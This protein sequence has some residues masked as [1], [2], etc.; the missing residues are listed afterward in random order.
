MDVPITWGDGTEGDMDVILT[1]ANAGIAS[2]PKRH[3][4]GFLGVPMGSPL[5]CTVS[6]HFTPVW[7]HHKMASN[8]VPLHYEEHGH[9]EPLILLHGFGGSGIDWAPF[10]EEWAADF[11]IIVPDLRGHGQSANPA[12]EFRHDAAAGDVQALLDRLGVESC[13]GL[14][15]SCGGNV[16]L[17]LATRQPERM[18]AMVLVSATSHF[19]EQARTIMRNYSFDLLPEEEKEKTR[20]RHPGG[21]AQIDTLFCAGARLRGELRRSE[22]H[23][24]RPGEDHGAHAHRA[25]R[26]RSVLSRADFGGHGGGHSAI[27]PVDRARRRPRSHRRRALAGICED[28]AGVFAGIGG[29]GRDVVYIELQLRGADG[30][31]AVFHLNCG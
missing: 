14:G 31:E 5:F 8:T 21:Q 22:F 10:A 6:G 4:H 24:A 15:V 27:Q 19:P 13:K 16:L 3:N 2:S 25:G 12:T 20:R 18:N 30:P 29:P 11:R 17:H 9:G 1:V 23:R 28:G 7:Y 26:S